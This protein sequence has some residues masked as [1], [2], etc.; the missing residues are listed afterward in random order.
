MQEQ[1]PFIDN[2]WKDL[3]QSDDV[4]ELLESLNIKKSQ[5]DNEKVAIVKDI[6]PTNKI[7]KQN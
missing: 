6:K 3:K 5:F 2:Y 1:S 4:D 7:Q